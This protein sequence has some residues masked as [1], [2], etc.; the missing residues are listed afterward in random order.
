MGGFVA[1]ASPDARGSDARRVCRSWPRFARAQVDRRPN[2]NHTEACMI[3][4]QHL[5]GANVIPI[6][7][8]NSLTNKLGKRGQ[9]RATVTNFVNKLRATQ[10]NEITTF[11]E[12]GAMEGN[13]GQL[14]FWAHN[15]KVEGSNPS[16]ATNSFFSS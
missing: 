3:A 15:P 9:C 14:K 2:R 4:S 8:S 10:G 1:R 6:P 11:G 13:C 12:S 16:P 5:S 7:L